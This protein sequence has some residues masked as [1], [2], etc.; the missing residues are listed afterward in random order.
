MMEVLSS[1]ETL[2]LTSATWCNIPEDGILHSHRR[3]NHKSYIS[4]CYHAFVLSM[5]TYF[6]CC[7][8]KCE[9]SALYGW[10]RQHMQGPEFILH[11]GPPFANGKPHIGHAVNKVQ[12]NAET[13]RYKSE[14]RQFET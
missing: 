7:L 11:D 8:Q 3:E 13:L 5:T 1:P 4:V 14:G 9:F 12:F 2:V 6:Y 10:Q